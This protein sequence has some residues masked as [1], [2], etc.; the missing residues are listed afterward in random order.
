MFLISMGAAVQ[1]L[2]VALAVEGLGLVLHIQHTVLPD[3]AG[4]AIGLPYDCHPM[5]AMGIGHPA[6]AAARARPAT[7]TTSS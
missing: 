6:A 5:G 4:D 7:R 2:M 3:V 1:N